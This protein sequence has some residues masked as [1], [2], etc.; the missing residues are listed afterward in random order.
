ME[1]I[2]TIITITVI[3]QGTLYLLRNIISISCSFWAA[4]WGYM[5]R[6]HHSCSLNFM[7]YRPYLN[8]VPYMSDSEK[9]HHHSLWVREKFP[10]LKT[11]IL[12][13]ISKSMKALIKFCLLL[14]NL[15]VVC[16]IDC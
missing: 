10:V 9:D 14:L 15:K 6:I 8:E 3:T 13:S 5:S 1:I 11:N 2:I 7:L 4:T 16:S 12:K